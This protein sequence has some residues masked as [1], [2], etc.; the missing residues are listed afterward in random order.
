MDVVFALQRQHRSALLMLRECITA[1]PAEVWVSGPEKRPFWRIAYHAA[2]FGHLYLVQ[3]EE[4]FQPWERHR[5]GANFTWSDEEDE[6]LE[7]YDKEDLLGYLDQ[8]IGRVDATVA[9]LDLSAGSGYHWYPEMTKLEHQILSIRHVQG[10]VGQLSELL[11]QHGID[12]HW[13]SKGVARV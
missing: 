10:H 6:V 9:G 8:V 5:E 13:I 11:M 12:T 3:N 4:A 1:C 2:Y 7:P